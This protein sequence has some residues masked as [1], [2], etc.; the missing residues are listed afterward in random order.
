MVSTTPTTHHRS[1]AA[2]DGTRADPKDQERVLASVLEAVDFQATE[3]TP[4][5]L[6]GSTAPHFSSRLKVLTYCY[7]IGLYPSLEI[8]SAINRDPLLRYLSEGERLESASLRQFRRR[9][10][11]ALTACL[12]Q[13]LERSTEESSSNRCGNRFPQRHY[14]SAS[15]DRWLPCTSPRD[16]D[17]EA[18]HRI[19]QAILLDT[20][21]LDD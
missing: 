19:R 4:A 2:A 21:S 9:H 3:A 13:A 1:P 17:G 16:F 20:A 14:A 7:A 10:R 15:L 6:L 18:V 12:A 8:E 11:L 5:S